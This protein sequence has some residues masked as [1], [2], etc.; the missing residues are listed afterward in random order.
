[1]KG[2]R[3]L[4]QPREHFVARESGVAEAGEDANLDVFRNP[5]A[6]EETRTGAE[7]V[8]LAHAGDVRVGAEDPP[9][10]RRAG[11]RRA[12]DDDARV[13]RFHHDTPIRASVMSRTDPPSTA[14]SRGGSWLMKLTGLAV[15]P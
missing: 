14:N 13:R 5:L 3:E 6:L 12:E 8:R 11:A 4:A 1:M 7:E 10:Q 15:R 9:Q 2:E